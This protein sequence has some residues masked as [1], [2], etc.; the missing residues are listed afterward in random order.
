MI[1][2][3]LPTYN[4][5]DNIKWLIPRIH[6]ILTKNNWKYEIIIVDDNSPDRTWEEAIKLAKKYNVKVIRR[7]KKLGLATAILEGILNSK[8]EICVVMDADGQHKPEDIPKLVKTILEGYDLAIGSR[9]IEEGKIT[10]WEERRSLISKFATWL[11]KFLFNLKVK[12][13]LSGFFAIRKE[14]IFYETKWHAIGYKILLEILVRFP[15][16]K[17]KEVPI[18]FEERKYGKSKLNIKEIINYLILILKL[19]E[20]RIFKFIIVGAL[21]ILV[22]EGLLYLLVKSKIPIYISSL[23][24]IELSLIHNFLWNY[25]WTFK[26]RSPFLRSL[27][28]YHMLWFTGGIT[29]YVVLLILTFLGFNYLIANLIGIFLAFLVNYLVSE[30]FIF[31]P[32]EKLNRNSPSF[33]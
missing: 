18:T 30:K 3:I 5:K 25:F 15:N 12:D 17:V 2:I 28:K 19:L 32:D 16:L 29:N 14:K 21:G 26:K 8:G 1:S 23:I 11:A 10:K 4:E 7:P 22:N 6:E 27:I 33:S 31:S 24:A 13:P 9:Y 20:Y